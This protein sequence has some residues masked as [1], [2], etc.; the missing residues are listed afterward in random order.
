[1]LLQDLGVFPLTILFPIRK[2]VRTIFIKRR[3]IILTSDA[4]TVIVNLEIS[5]Y[6][7]AI[8]KLR[9]DLFYIQ[10]FKTSLAPV[11]EMKFIEYLLQKLVDEMNA[12]RE[13]L[14]R[15]DKRRAVLRAVGS[16]LKWF[17]WYGYIVRC[18]GITQGSR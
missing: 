11:R 14:P 3:D 7:P 17:F 13:I 16:V 15:L 5:T 10:K 4:R 12:F 6:E 8:A 1:M 2:F 18:R 9:H